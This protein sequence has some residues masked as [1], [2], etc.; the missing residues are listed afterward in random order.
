MPTPADLE[1]KLWK[2]LKSDRTVMRDGGIIDA[3]LPDYRELDDLMGM[4]T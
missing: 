4:P 1:A 2:S 3:A